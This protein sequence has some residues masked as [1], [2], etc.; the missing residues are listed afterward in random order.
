M[1]IP[2]KSFP[3]LCNW[4]DCFLAEFWFFCIY[5]GYKSISD[6]WFDN[7]LV[8]GLSFHSLKNTGRIEILIFMK[9]SWSVYS[10]MGHAFGVITKNPLPN[11]RFQKFF[12]IFSSRSFIVLGF[13]IRSVIHVELTFLPWVR[14]RSKLTFLNM[15]IQLFHYHFLKRLPF[16]YCIAFAPFWKSAVHT[17]VGLFLSSKVSWLL[18]LSNNVSLEIDVSLLTL[19]LFSKLFKLFQA[20]CIFIKSAYQILQKSSGNLVR[21]CCIH[22]QL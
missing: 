14:H 5:S 16:L 21:L 18:Q 20:L 8:Y 15:D 3:H 10:S 22:G 17:C 13:T 11:S 6:V 4:V 7:T 1:K 12:S 9:F 2:F 19:S